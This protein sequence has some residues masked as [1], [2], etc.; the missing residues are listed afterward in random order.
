[1]I[2]VKSRHNHKQIIEVEKIA[3]FLHDEDL[4]FEASQFLRRDMRNWDIQ[5]KGNISKREAKA[6]KAHKESTNKSEKPTRTA[7][8]PNNSALEE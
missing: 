5:C 7:W 8:F 4:P 6:I 2:N 1:M 3:S